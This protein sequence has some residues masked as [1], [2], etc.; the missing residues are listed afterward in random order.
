MSTAAHPRQASAA[1]PLRQ[2]AAIGGRALVAVGRHPLLF[3]LVYGTHLIFALLGWGLA[4]FLAGPY[5]AGRPATALP[6]WAF[7]ARLLEAEALRAA[8]AGAC[9]LGGYWIAG[10]ALAAVVLRRLRRLPALSR[11]WRCWGRLLLLRATQAIAVAAL[12]L[13]WW[14]AARHL[15]Q[16]CLRWTDDR[17]HVA[18][19][20]AVALCFALPSLSVLVIGHYAQLLVAA[21]QGA[22]K[23]VIGSLALL[24]RR[25]GLATLLYLTGWAMWGALALLG[26][27]GGAGELAVGQLGV[28]GR[29]A[30]HLWIYA[31]AW[32]LFDLPS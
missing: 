1:A 18:V 20:A 26:W 11:F 8:A 21:G 29:V 17:L 5:L 19:Q 31:A 3:C 27:G 25:C 10:S 13:G 30:L 12:L 15:H 6:E 9:L 28:L 4:V 24:R 14:V 2:V 32:A 23:A 16:L 7:L 22:A